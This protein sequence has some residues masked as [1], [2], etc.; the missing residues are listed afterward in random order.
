[1]KTKQFTSSIDRREFIKKAAFAI[2][3]AAGAL[4]GT[5]E[6]AEAWVGINSVQWGN[7]IVAGNY[8]GF[9]ESARRFI[10]PCRETQI[11]E[12]EMRRWLNNMD[13]FFKK[14]E[15][16]TGTRPKNNLGKA[17]IVISNRTGLPTASAAVGSINLPERFFVRTMLSQVRSTQN[18]ITF[19]IMHEMS[20]LFH[21]IHHPNRHPWSQNE[22]AAELIHAYAMENPVGNFEYLRGANGAAR[23]HGLLTSTA[24]GNRGAINHFMD[25]VNNLIAGRNHGFNRFGT[26]HERDNLYNMYML[27]LPDVVGWDTMSKAVRSYYQDS[28][29][30]PTRTYTANATTV[31]QANAHEFF[32]R[33]AFFH[34]L[35]VTNNDLNLVPLMGRRATGEQIVADLPARLLMHENSPFRRNLNTAQQQMVRQLSQPGPNGLFAQFF[36]VAEIAG[37]T[38]DVSGVFQRCPHTSSQAIAQR[39]QTTTPQPQSAD[40]QPTPTA[41]TTT[42]PSATERQPGTVRRTWT[43]PDL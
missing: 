14:C 32:D 3:G 43:N 2:G 9:Q 12:Q 27:G 42:Q 38:P 17:F 36:E 13:R 31:S 35:K 20:H 41:P 24:T 33:V 7:S 8:V 28:E 22:T 40:Q 6:K 37:R 30:R 39:P 23:R 15:E 26:K 25:G 5:Q 16:F 1:M 34:N 4:L 10:G 19:D 21:V 18:P 29:F 11:T